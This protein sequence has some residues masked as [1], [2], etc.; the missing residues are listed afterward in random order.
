MS[1]PQAAALRAES[2]ALAAVLAGLPAAA[3]AAPTRCAP[4][5]VRDVVGHIVVGLARVPGLPSADGEADTDIA[6]YFR[7]DERFSETTNDERVRVAQDRAAAEPTDLIRDLV[8][9]ARA[10]DD[11]YRE[12]GPDRIVRTRHGDAMRLADFIATRV[13]EVAVHGLDIADALDLP[14]WLTPAAAGLLP[15]ALAGPDWWQLGGDPVDVLRQLT[16][17]TTAPPA[18]DGLAFG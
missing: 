5:L 16:G 17:R 11:A 12:S 6:G 3:W 8:D 2:H 1:D 4:W 14:P 10:A 18:E 13:V 9:A 7:G 15:G